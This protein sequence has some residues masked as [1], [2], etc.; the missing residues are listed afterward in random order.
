MK[1]I[2]VSFFLLLAMPV[3][4]RYNHADGYMYVSA[5]QV[6]LGAVFN[7]GKNLAKPPYYIFRFKPVAKGVDF[8]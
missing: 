4:A 5:A 7:S 6:H 3:F 1:S 8:R 2:I